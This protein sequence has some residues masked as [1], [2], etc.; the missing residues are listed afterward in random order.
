[1]QWGNSFLRDRQC[2]SEAT[3]YPR[4]MRDWL[5]PLPLPLLVIVSIP[6]LVILSIL[7]LVILSIP[8][9]VILSILLLV[10]LS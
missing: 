4:S 7:L 3:A 8:L 1:M 10:I 5:S 2:G 6:L 9:L